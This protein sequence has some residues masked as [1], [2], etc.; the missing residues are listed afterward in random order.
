MDHI[1]TVLIVVFMWIM[2][3][4]MWRHEP[5]RVAVSNVASGITL[6]LAVFILIWIASGQTPAFSLTSMIVACILHA[7]LW[8]W[9]V[10]RRKPTSIVR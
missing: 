10:S 4:L 3:L 7:L 2:G 8:L 6:V 1:P 5:K 9:V